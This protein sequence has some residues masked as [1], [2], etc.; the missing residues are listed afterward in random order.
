MASSEDVRVDNRMF[1]LVA[2][3]GN[4]SHQMQ[5]EVVLDVKQMMISGIP[6]CSWFF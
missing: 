4:M 5:M 1:E 3:T 2:R 6:R